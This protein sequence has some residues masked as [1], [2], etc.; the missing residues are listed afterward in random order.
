M[1]SPFPASIAF[2]WREDSAGTAPALLPEE[3]AALGSV[4]SPRRRAQFALGRACARDALRALGVAVPVAIAKGEDRRPVWP[5]GIVGSI[6]HSHERAAAAAAPARLFRGIGLD[7]ERIRAPSTALLHRVCRPE[8]RPPFEALSPNTAARRFTAVF[9]A[10]ESVYKAVNPLTGV[11]LGF[12]DAGI[13]FPE[14]ED[15]D[16]GSP[17]LWRL[18]KAGGPGFP[19]GTRGQGAWRRAGEWI[20]AGVWITA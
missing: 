4:A 12:Q 13:E 15:F 19:A 5:A 11:Y 8:E 2:A 18:E 17:F 3:E 20:L 1:D 14:G 9:A 7:L 10:K 16:T 6:T